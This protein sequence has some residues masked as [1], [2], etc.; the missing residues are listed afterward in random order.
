MRARIPGQARNNQ[1]PLAGLSIAGAVVRLVPSYG[2]R[3]DSQIYGCV[4]GMVTRKIFGGDS[5]GVKFPS[6]H[7]N[8]CFLSHS[9]HRRKS[10]SLF[11]CS[12][13]RIC[14]ETLFDLLREND[15]MNGNSNQ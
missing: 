5:R 14:I 8:Q 13:N 3:E 12:A 7:T 9:M 1:D 4:Y 2:T 11:N 10:T 15:A 6:D